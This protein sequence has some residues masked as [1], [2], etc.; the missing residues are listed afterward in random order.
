MG[1]I[2]LLLALLSSLSIVL[3]LRIYEKKGLTKREAKH[4]ISAL[5]LKPE[6]LEKLVDRLTQKEYREIESKVTSI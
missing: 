2:F 1:N 5:N 3:L 6:V 4:N